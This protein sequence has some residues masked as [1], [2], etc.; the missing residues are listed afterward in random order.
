MRYIAVGAGSV[1]ALD[2][3]VSP[4]PGDGMAHPVALPHRACQS[5]LIGAQHFPS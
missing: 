3:A 2:A 1:A 5:G 4:P